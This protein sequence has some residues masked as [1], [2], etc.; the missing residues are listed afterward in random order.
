MPARCV[1][2]LHGGARCPQVASYLN[3]DN[4]KRWCA[5]HTPSEAKSVSGTKHLCRQEGCAKT[6][7]YGHP[8]TRCTMHASSPLATADAD[9]PQ[10]EVCAGAPATVAV[11]VT[12]KGLPGAVACTGC[13]EVLLEHAAPP[14]C[15]GGKC[16]VCGERRSSY[17]F[18]YGKPRF[19]ARDAPPGTVNVRCQVR[20][21]E[22]AQPAEFG[23]AR[24]RW[25]KT[26]A[27]GGWRCAWLVCEKEGCL[28]H[29]T[30]ALRGYTKELRWCG[31]HAPRSSTRVLA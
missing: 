24:G 8:A 20:C 25:C 15:E 7:R 2:L 4:K 28:V 22:C 30:H 16:V 5:E 27:R 10:C 21:M 31:A 14:R 19:C 12:S 9:R 6:A 1:G 23:T 29:A 18:E 17:G 3:D 11:H 13:A 26:H